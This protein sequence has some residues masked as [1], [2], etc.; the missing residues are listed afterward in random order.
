MLT[1]NITLVLGRVTPVKNKYFGS[2]GFPN[3]MVR[4]YIVPLLGREWGTVELV[5]TG[6]LSPNMSA[7]DLI[8]TPKYLRV[9]LMS[10][11]CSVAVLAATN[12]DP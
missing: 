2:Y 5:T 6:L 8:G 4:Q 9:C 12:S 1:E 7:L 11:I 3:S 10:T